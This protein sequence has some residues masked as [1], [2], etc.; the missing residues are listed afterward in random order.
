MDHGRQTL[1]TA[2]TDPE[3]LGL[4]GVQP[5]VVLPQSKPGRSLS[6]PI[7]AARRGAEHTAPGL[8][9]QGDRFHA[10]PPEV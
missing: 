2:E 1:E 8:A 5:P 3:P 6:H 9:E 10:R 7:E 4:L